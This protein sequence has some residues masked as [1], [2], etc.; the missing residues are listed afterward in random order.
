MGALFLGLL[1][2]AG[3]KAYFAT[4][5]VVGPTVGSAGTPITPPPGV[6]PLDADQT[7]ELRRLRRRERQLLSE[8]AWVDRNVGVAR[9]P[10]RRAIEIL[11]Q[12]PRPTGQSNDRTDEQ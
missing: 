2:M 10:I 3:L 5:R 11:S 1:L 12:S 9:I 6:A 8:Y 7:S 4:T